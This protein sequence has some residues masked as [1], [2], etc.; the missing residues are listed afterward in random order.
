M[1]GR[2]LEEAMSVFVI[3]LISLGLAMDALAVAA[4]RVTTWRRVRACTN[5]DA[6]GRLGT[7]CQAEVRYC[8]F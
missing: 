7:G 5:V 8:F 4:A 3:L 6:F 2:A 1:P